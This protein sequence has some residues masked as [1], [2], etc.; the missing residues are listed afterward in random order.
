M[1]KTPLNINVMKYNKEGKYFF[2]DFDSG[3]MGGSSP[4]L[5]DIFD[6]IPQHTT[7][8]ILEKLS[9]NKYTTENI[10]TCLRQLGDL[11]E[12]GKLFSKQYLKVEQKKEKLSHLWLNIA[13][14]CNMRC[15]YCYAHGGNYGGDS[16]FMDKETAKKCIDYWYKN[17][18]NSSKSY[19]F[20]FGG[21]PFLNKEIIYFSI[22]YINE[23]F[24]PLGRKA[25]YSITTNG[26]IYD[27]DF[28]RFLAKNDVALLFSIDGD[29]KIQNSNRPFA[30]G[31][32]S[33]AVV[34]DNIKKF[35]QLFKKMHATIVVT[36]KSIPKLKDSVMHLWD[37]GFNEVAS[38]IVITQDQEMSLTNDSLKELHSQVSEL[39]K[40]MYE[41]ILSR[42]HRLYTNTYRLC[43]SIHNNLKGSDCSFQ[44]DTA[45][46]FTPEGDMHK[47]HRLIDKK[48]FS[49]CNVG[50][51][52]EWSEANRSFVEPLEN[53]VCKD[54]WAVQL[55]GGGCP[56]EGYVY[57][58]DLNKPFEV[59]CRHTKF[60]IEEAIKLYFNIYVDMPEHINDIFGMH[61]KS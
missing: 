58:N 32:G 51:A 9:K 6:M 30:S 8:E 18:D 33:Y 11:Y 36:K 40:I 39:N 59:T 3:T 35:N 25:F 31:K 15:I 22:N 46:M 44:A 55:C 20:F 60:L 47:C 41:N 21:E 54:C 43:M 37:L 38:S 10:E 56:H 48:E 17:L 45:V 53:R 12:K 16:M 27:E 5:N 13:H 7:K 34:Y 28:A 49:L 19:I 23:L 14:Q 2:Y 52:Q 42:R 4:I 24:K 29:E 61:N 26:T 50:E 57:N 1:L